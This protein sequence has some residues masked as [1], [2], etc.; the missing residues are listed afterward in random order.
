MV[1]LRAKR[2]NREGWVGQSLGRPDGP[3]HAIWAARTS[4]RAA[5]GASQMAAQPEL[6]PDGSSILFVKDGQIYRAQ[7]SRR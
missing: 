5:H 7:A 6:A 4:G 1:F 2:P 3:E